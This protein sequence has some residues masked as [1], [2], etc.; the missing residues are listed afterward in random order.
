MEYLFFIFYFGY[1]YVQFGLSGVII[2]ILAWL[3][4][5]LA[6]IYGPIAILFLVNYKDVKW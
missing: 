1:C 5:A 4:M 6:F 2:N 3:G